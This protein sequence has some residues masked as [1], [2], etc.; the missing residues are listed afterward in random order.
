MT[1]ALI[2]GS[3]PAAAGAALAL[4][5]QRDLEVSVLDVGLRLEADRLHAVERL[6]A[7]GPEAWPHE[8]LN[9]VASR[10]VT[11]TEGGLPEKRSY[12]SDFPF[13]DVGQLNGFTAGPDVHRRVMSAAY[14]GFSNV[15]GAQV[16]P[17]SAATFEG[18]PVTSAEMEPHYRAVLDRIPFAGE[19]DDLADLFPL[20]GSPKP[21]PPLTERSTR[22]LAAYARH[23]A[24]LQRSGVTVGKAR[25]AMS[26]PACVSCGLCMSGCP[27]GLIYSAAQTF[28]ELCRTGRINYLGGLL[29]TSVTEDQDSASVVAMEPATGRRHRFEAD[30]VYVA[31][32]GLA[33]T[34]LVLGSLRMFDR[35]VTMGESVQ[36][37]LPMLSMRATPDPRRLRQFTL[38]QFNMV[39]ALDRRGLDVSQIH[40]YTYDPAFLDAL[41]RPL[42]SR[43]ME[44]VML[45]VLRR[46]TVGLGYLPSWASPRLRV[47]ARPPAGDGMPE[48]LVSREPARWAQNSMLRQVLGKVTRA[49][50]LLDLYPA[51]PTIKL[52]PGGK[53][54]HF[55]GSFPH[56]R[57]NDGAGG[58]VPAASDTLGRIGAWKRIHLVD[59]AVLPSVAATTFTLTVMANAHRIA[60][61]SL[62]GPR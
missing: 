33:T 4:T 17:Y 18:W 60:T 6:A 27:Y 46:L 38:N 12:G 22:V 57:G 16:M 56:R 14:G 5:A 59:A 26:S 8:L 39:V 54:Y 51:I 25:L 45:Q 61:E 41:P 15:W 11:S 35:E 21:L 23:R 42:R 31:C 53:S 48:L 44:P 36:F 40:F 10:P 1:K 9:L 3:G 29:A 2:I 34:R 28:D 24:A 62:Q 13:R 7:T 58:P 52:A 43:A 30:R 20:I 37:M 47:R 50:P 19:E 32:G 49:A 55:G